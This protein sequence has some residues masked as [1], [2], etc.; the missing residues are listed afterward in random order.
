M[1]HFNL[2]RT[3]V[4][5]AILAASA[6]VDASAA[7]FTAINT[8][9]GEPSLF[10]LLDGIYGAGNY[11]RI[12]DDLDGVWVAD[13]IVGA[14]A[15]AKTANAKQRLG[16]CEICDG[17]DNFQFGPT[18]TQNGVFAISLFDGTYSFSGPS[19]RWYDAA[20]GDP[21]VAT[22]YSDPLLNPRGVDQM[23]TFAIK[24]RPGVFVLG[25]EDRPSGIR[26]VA[27]DRDFNDFI[28][29][30]RFAPQQPILTSDPQPPGN[31]I[32][33]SVPEP[34]GIAL[35]GGALLALGLA[36]RKRRRS[37]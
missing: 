5:V 34:T 17:T 11:E 30:V 15:M 12:S 22:A 23:V 28:V 24:N 27:S 35:L 33:P 19:F 16:V 7:A 36:G 18:I 32:I 3:A 10:D 21:Y 4:T 31:E 29:E 8:S 20:F 25:F 37:A 2:I 13:D 14:T 6:A 1:K 26:Y 9:S